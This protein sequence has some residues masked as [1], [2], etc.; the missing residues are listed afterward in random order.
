MM[1]V[2][3]ADGGDMTV[4]MIR[5][6]TLPHLHLFGVTGLDLKVSP[7]ARSQLTFY[8]SRSAGLPR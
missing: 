1:G 7:S 8:R 4:D 6:V 5:T 2:T 3:G